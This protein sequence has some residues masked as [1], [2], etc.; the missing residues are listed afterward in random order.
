MPLKSGRNHSFIA[1][2]VYPDW[3][4]PAGVSTVNRHAHTQCVL[5]KYENGP[6]IARGLR[7]ALARNFGQYCALLSPVPPVLCIL[8][9]NT[10][11][12]L[13]VTHVDHG[14]LRLFFSPPRSRH[15]PSG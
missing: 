14:C 9:T 3:S 1:V 11:A 5:D 4:A 10:Q 7:H 15:L 13:S 12:A 8:L 6:Y 2:R